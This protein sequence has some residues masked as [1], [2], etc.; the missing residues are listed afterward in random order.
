MIKKFIKAIGPILLSALLLLAVFLILQPLMLKINPTYSLLS[1]RGLGKVVFITLVIVTILGF[2]FTQSK[3]FIKNFLQ[4]NLYFF[5]DK[6]FIKLF[7]KYFLIF[8]VLHA[9]LLFIFYFSGYAIF[10][11]NW[12]QFNFNLIFKILFGFIVVFM[13]AW[14]EELIFR[15]TLFPYFEQHFSTFTSL[16]LTSV[17]FMFVHDLKNPLNL[18]TTNW[19]LGLGLFL[20]GMLLNLIFIKTRKLYTNMGAHAGLVFVKVILRRAPLLIFLDQQ[21]LPFWV[22]KDLRMSALIHILFL[23]LIIYLIIKNKQCSRL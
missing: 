9:F 17:I 12:G 3:S 16:I 2:I 18:I 15:G 19:Q 8:F 13:L 6:K 21:N 10:N 23:I 20:L 14:T 7:F 22:N 1:S 11:N 4:T 5:K